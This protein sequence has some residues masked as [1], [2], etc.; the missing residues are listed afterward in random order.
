MEIPQQVKIQII[1]DLHLEFRD[2]SKGYDFLRVS[3]PILVM[4]GDICALGSAS[5]FKHYEKFISHIYG[6][7]EC[8][9]HI[10]GNH[11]YYCS[12]AKTAKSRKTMT[13]IETKIEEFLKPYPKV[14]YMNKDVLKLNI[15]GKKYYFICCTM[16][17]KIAKKSQEEMKELM[18]DYSYIWT[19]RKNN[20]TPSD[21]MDMHKK[22]TGFIKRAIERAQR[23]SAIAI[24]ITHHKPYLSLDNG[25]GG[26]SIISDAYEVDMVKQIKAPVVAWIYGHTH[27][28]D[29]SN[30]NGVK[31]VSN[32]LGYPY[33]RGTGFIKGFYIAI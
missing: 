3:A 14:H 18:N 12:D 1:S 8:I 22:S 27:K 15:R 26:E 4:A 17:S 31:I 5:D 19:D 11:E 9:I 6:K 32:P 25:S 2:P 7:Y 29:N 10:P 28:A 30:I 33:Q 16:W 20:L 24:V 13:E 23:D 21:V